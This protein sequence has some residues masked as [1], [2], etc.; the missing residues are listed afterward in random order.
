MAR[1]F[2]ALTRMCLNNWHYISEKVLSF[3]EDINFFTGHSGSG[4]STV[5]DALQIVLYADSNGKGFF[6]KAAKDDSDRTLME[7][8]RGMRVVQDNN[9]ASYVRNKNF[10][11]EIVL[12]FQNTENKAYQCIGVVFDVDVSSNNIDRLFFWH[13]GRFLNENYRMDGKAMSI[14][15]VKAYLKDRFPKESY[16]YSRTNEKFRSRMYETYFGG[17]NEKKFPALFKKAIPFRMNMKLEDFVKDYVCTECDIHMEDMQDSVIQYVRLKRKLEDTKNELELLTK[18]RTQYENYKK[19]KDAALQ[20]EYNLEKLA[21][22]ELD[23]RLK[24]IDEKQKV[25][26]FDV[27]NLSHRAESLSSEISALQLKRDEIIVALENSGYTHLEEELKSLDQIYEFLERSKF[28]YGAA[29][30]A[31]DKWINLDLL[32][33]DGRHL[34]K[35]FQDFC[36]ERVE[37][38]NLQVALQDARNNVKKEK[39]L[40]EDKLREN[41]KLV[42]EIAMQIAQLKQGQKAYP[43]YLIEAK[44]YISERLEKIYEREIPVNILSDL[45]EISD[46]AWRN[47]VEGYMG[48]HKLTLMVPPEYAKAAIEIYKELDPKKYHR[49]SVV[50]TDKIGNEKKGACKGALSEEVVTSISYVRAYIDFLMG[51]VIKCKDVNELREKTCG[52]TADCLLYQGYKIQHINPTNYTEYTYIGKLAIEKR[53]NQLENEWKQGLL[54]QEPYKEKIKK[55]NEILSFES[56]TQDSGIYEKYLQDIQCMDRTNK[57]KVAI[58]KKIIQLKENNM[59]EWQKQKDALEQ[60]V[61]L[62]MSQKERY[63]FESREKQRMLERFAL[64]IISLQETLSSLQQNFVM[65]SEREKAFLAYSDNLNL[66][67]IEQLKV[68]MEKKKKKEEG[69]SEKEFNILVSVRESYGKAFSYR[70]FSISSKDNDKYDILL[71]ELYSDKLPI[72][73]EKANE[74]AKVAVYHFKTDFIYKIRDAIKEAIQ[75][76]DDLNRILANADFGK[77]RYRFIITKNKGEDGKFFD[78]FMDE[79]LEINPTNLSNNMENQMNIFTMEHEE[80]YRN[81]IN[82][83]IDMFMPPDNDDPRALEESRAN[84]EKYTDYRTYLSF[85]MEQIIEGMPPMRL[86]RMLSK[87]SGGEGQN[88]LYVALLGSFAQVYRINE[89]SNLRRNPTPRLVVLD[90]AFSKMDAEKVGSCIRLIRNLGF[91]AII[92]ATNDKIQ[93]YVDN[94][95][96]TFV[97]ANPNKSHISIQEFEKNDFKD[98]LS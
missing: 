33:Q 97:Y 71:N 20:Y 89:R 68:E 82:E 94:V 15:E 56:L 34:I 57:K 86:S 10:S 3:H 13:Q 42:H 39:A 46:D 85:D 74:Q 90:E 93:N 70:G 76:K 79:N 7:Y 62:K 50:D 28:S 27:G 65:N 35:K 48:N 4:K 24:E 69:E 17:L 1:R 72:F 12:E 61:K 83:L 23:M 11:T 36:I 26:S 84:M 88:P 45:I 41:E 44:Q 32:S 95:D 25:Y 47:A 53:L 81:L 55:Y 29:A 87:N 22:L 96:K 5:I 91:Q 38:E 59:E 6:N 66:R 37:I 19:H 31:L 21:I 60:T 78:M 58:E 98:L 52:I 14:N 67:K 51:N 75:Q 73:M 92:S 8:L 54:E 80:H 16:E 30:T 64:D 63:T 40:A 18:I 49:V 77:D 2:E 43:K 9:E